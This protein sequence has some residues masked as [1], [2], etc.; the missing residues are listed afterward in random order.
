MKVEDEKIAARIAATTPTTI[1]CFF[2][3]QSISTRL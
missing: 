2:H 1:R 3:F